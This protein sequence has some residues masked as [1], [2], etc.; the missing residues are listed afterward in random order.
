MGGKKDHGKERKTVATKVSGNERKGEREFRHHNGTKESSNSMKF[1]ARLLNRQRR[2][3]KKKENRTNG[4]KKI[5]GY[6]RI[7]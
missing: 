1:T 7:S 5:L 4:K 3:G 6:D 2:R